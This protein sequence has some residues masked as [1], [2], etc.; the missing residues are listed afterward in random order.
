MSD[1]NMEREA[2]ESALQVK[3][4]A[5]KRQQKL[6]EEVS[7]LQ[8]QLTELHS[9]QNITSDV[10]VV[11][12]CVHVHVYNYLS[13]VSFQLYGNLIKCVLTVGKL[14]HNFYNG[15]NMFFEHSLSLSFFLSLTR[16]HTLQDG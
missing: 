4:M 11:C 13:Q 3:E 10:S 7:S 14:G 2:R 15:S 6:S 12:V 5:E 16:T 8:K 9:A 1:F